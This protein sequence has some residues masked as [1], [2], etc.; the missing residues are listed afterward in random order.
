MVAKGGA[1][2]DVVNLLPATQLT[3][4]GR[5]ENPGTW[6]YQPTPLPELS[7]PT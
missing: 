5:M 2:V 6:L 1:R 4:E 3:L 7:M